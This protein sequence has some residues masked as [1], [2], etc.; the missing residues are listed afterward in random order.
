MGMR[1]VT[2]GT[3]DTIHA[4]H[5][6]LFNQCLR[7]AGP[8]GQLIV[9]INSDEFVAKYKKHPP[10]V[11]Y[12]SR[13]AVIRNL[14]QVTGTFRNSLDWMQPQSIA[15]QNPDILVV[16]EDWARNNYLQQINASQHWLDS[17]NIQ[18]CYVPRTGD[19]SSTAIKEGAHNG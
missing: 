14:R 16:G 17:N 8:D 6:G 5:I 15:A 4:G 10:L 2:V 11:P 7:L 1:V 9:G 12:E 13:A 3:F 19:W 18:L